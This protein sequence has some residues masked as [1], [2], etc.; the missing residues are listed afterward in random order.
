M[1]GAFYMSSHL[2]QQPERKVVTS[3]LQMRNGDS[4]TLNNQSR[5]Q[6]K[7]LAESRLGTD[8]Y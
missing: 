6:S 3:V 1:A 2:I 5:S 4:K 8:S 7:S